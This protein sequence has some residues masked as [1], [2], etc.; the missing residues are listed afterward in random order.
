MLDEIRQLGDLV[1]NQFKLRNRAIM[2]M[3]KDSGLRRGDICQMNIE[4]YLGA[5]L[6][7]TQSGSFRVY[8]PYET[9]MFPG[10]IYRMKKPKAVILLFASGRVV[11]VGCKSRE[12]VYEAV[13]KMYEIL[14]DY[15]LLYTPK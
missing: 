3:L 11:C 6:I 7:E 4:H 8:A 12:L 5:R 10:L 1:S 2:M 15:G 13:E 9:E 14:Q